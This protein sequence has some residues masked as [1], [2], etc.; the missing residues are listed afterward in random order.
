MAERLPLPAGLFV[1]TAAALASEAAFGAGVTGGVVGGG[2]GFSFAG[3]L[4][5]TG[6]GICRSL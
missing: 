5:C 4:I 2:V 6:S 1:F 3:G